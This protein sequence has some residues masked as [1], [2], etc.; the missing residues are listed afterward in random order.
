MLWILLIEPL[1]RYAF[2]IYIS[3]DLDLFTHTQRV[4]N[5]ETSSDC[6]KLIMFFSDGG[7]EWPKEVLDKYVFVKQ[8][9]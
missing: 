6:H 3:L 9:K 5:G 7:T 2:R 4:R 8:K 1:N